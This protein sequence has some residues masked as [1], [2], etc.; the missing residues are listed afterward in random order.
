LALASRWPFSKI[1]EHSL[2]VTDRAAVFPWSAV[3]VA[4]IRAPQPF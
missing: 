2:D 4:E 1:H 3:V